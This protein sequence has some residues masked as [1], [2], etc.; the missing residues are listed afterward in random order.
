[1]AIY[2]INR[3]SQYWGIGEE[4]LQLGEGELYVA[5]FRL[6]HSAIKQMSQEGITA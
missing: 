5:H 1:M 2:A 6:E 3:T 4:R